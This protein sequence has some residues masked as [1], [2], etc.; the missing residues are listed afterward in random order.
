[1]LLTG[2]IMEK[3]QQK[4]GSLARRAAIV[5]QDKRFGLWLDRRRTAKF[6]MN[7]PDG[8]HTPTD[9]KDFILQYCEVESR[10]ELDHNPTAANKFFNVLK[11]YNKFLRRLNQ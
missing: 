4:G 3:E 1:V 5:C 8:T 7:I 11:H 6:N 10:R 2:L 9:A